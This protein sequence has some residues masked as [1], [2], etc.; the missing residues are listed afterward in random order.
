MFSNPVKCL[1]N[2]K[3]SYID[4]EFLINNSNLGK[5]ILK[6]FN[7]L[8][9]K[10]L[11]D[12]SRKEIDL[13]KQNEEIVKIKNVISEEEL[14]KKI[15]I[16]KLEIKE[17]NIHKEKIS[18]ETNK[19]RNKEIENFFKKINPLI[20]KYMD[21]NS[22]DIIIDKKNIFIARSEYDITKDILD[23]INKNF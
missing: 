20:Q 5:Q 1:G 21:E 17:F 16:L 23:L 9:T 3:I 22:I 15:K 13:K 6:T 8:K 12:L 19:L 10:N 11:E 2:D 7:D 4:I 14:E 18:L